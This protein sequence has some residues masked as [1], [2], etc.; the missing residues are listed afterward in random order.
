[1]AISVVTVMKLLLP[2]YTVGWCRQ[3][4]QD[5]MFVHTVTQQHIKL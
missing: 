2:L 5:H 4:G 1:V 3:S